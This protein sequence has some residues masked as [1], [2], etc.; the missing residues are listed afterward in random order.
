VAAA[1]Q[2]GRERGCS[3]LASDALLDNEASHRFHHAAGFAET[4]RVVYF[5]KPL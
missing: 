4:E 1:G 2:W 5:R 3:E